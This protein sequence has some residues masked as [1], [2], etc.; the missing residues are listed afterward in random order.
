MNSPCSGSMCVEEL[1]IRS[2]IEPHH[3]ARRFSFHRTVT[4]TMADVPASATQPAKA[5]QPASTPSATPAASTSSPATATPA[6]STAEHPLETAWTFYFDRKLARDASAA[7]SAASFQT[8]AQNLQ[9]VGRFDTIEGFWR[10][11]AYMQQPDQIPRDHN[12][13]RQ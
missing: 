11:Y 1:H 7:S 12:L 2:P 5:T 3:I 4:V 13:Y 8:F 10:H 9:K 6:A